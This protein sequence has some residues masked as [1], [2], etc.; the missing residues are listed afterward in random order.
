MAETKNK[1]RSKGEGSLEF[2]EQKNRW[3]ARIT[4]HRADGSSFRKTFEGKTQK[5]V[6]SKR[7]E[8]LKQHGNLPAGKNETAYL[9]DYVMNWLQTT[10]RGSIKAGTYER[11]LRAFSTHIFPY[12]GNI[13]L[14]NLDTLTIQREIINRMRDEKDK[15]GSPAQS[16]S[17]IKK[18]YSPLN[19]CLKYAV[20]VGD[21]PSNPCDNLTLPKERQSNAKKIH[22]LSDDETKRFILACTEDVSKHWWSFLIMLYTGLREGEVC[23]LR[24]ADVHLDSLDGKYSYIDVHATIV[25]NIDPETGKRLSGYIYQG[26]TKTSKDRRAYF[27]EAAKALFVERL[28]SCPVDCYLSSQ[29]TAPVNLVYLGRAFKSVLKHADIHNGCTLHDLRH[30]C[31]TRLIRQGTDVKSVSLQLGHSNIQTTL[32]IYVHPSEDDRAKAMCSLNWD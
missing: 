31:A 15:D 10:K 26:S 16:Y 3:V 23:A 28:K 18:V 32:N 4:A 20:K 22:P 7:D 19:S 17:N 1:R 5:E 24:P 27:G 8:W 21:I 25:P 11:Y 30:T 13:R 6:R 9:S 29:S 12:I 14:I 2:N